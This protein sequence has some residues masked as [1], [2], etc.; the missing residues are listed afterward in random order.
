VS[1]VLRALDA[2]NHL[3]A[4]WRGGGARAS[5]GAASR[6]A[7]PLLLSVGSSTRAHGRRNP[8]VSQILCSHQQSQLSAATRRSIGFLRRRFG[9]F[10]FQRSYATRSFRRI[11]LSTESIGGRNLLDAVRHWSKRSTHRTR[12]TLRSIRLSISIA[13]P[14]STPAQAIPQPQ[15]VS[16][17][18]KPSLQ[19]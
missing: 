12:C 13:L 6:L 1:G 17:Q 11:A 4:N 18:K 10:H 16:H 8:K 15:L 19:L 7:E 2:R 3:G 9:L 5:A 14:R